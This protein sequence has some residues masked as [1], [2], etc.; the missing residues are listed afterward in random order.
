M[1]G[2]AIPRDAIPRDAGPTEAIAKVTRRTA[3]VGASLAAILFDPVARAAFPQ[4]PS[5]RTPS[6]RPS[7]KQPSEKQRAGCTLGFSTYGMKT[8]STEKSIRILTNIGYDSV[9]II[10]RSEWDAD[11]AKLSAQRRKSLRKHLADSKLQL[12]SLM[13]HVFPTT[14]QQQKVALERLKLAAGVAHDLSPN[15]PPHIQTVLGGG[16]FQQ[17]KN[18]LRDRLG[19]WL[20]LAESTATTICIKPHR[21]GVVSQPAE[22]VWLLEQ[23][24]SP[25]RLRMVYDY[26]HYAYRE[27]PL[28]DTIRTAL[29]FTSYIAVKD[30]VEQDGRVVFKLPGAAKTIDFAKL[31]QQFH[32]GG[33]RGDFNCEVSSMVS[34]QNGYDPIA[35]A[36]ECYENVDQAFRMAAVPRS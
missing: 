11:S 21:G 3:I 20:K 7:E 1:S 12:T 5:K 28:V 26:S 15:S 23:L 10:V 13:E 16:D 29:P 9:E 35:A 36:K 18:T 22:A 31:I 6:K 25:E 2:D 27:L 19:D 30:A 8:L 34:G 14:D 32:T 24:G 33:Y 4:S 17:Q